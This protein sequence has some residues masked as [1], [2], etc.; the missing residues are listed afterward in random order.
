MDLLQQLYLYCILYT[1]SHCILHTFVI[2]TR[3]MLILQ[4][5]SYCGAG[6]GGGGGGER[7]LEGG[8][9]GMRGS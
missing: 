4:W 8:G 7:V 1:Y 5:G 2:H 6:M 3:V 9:G